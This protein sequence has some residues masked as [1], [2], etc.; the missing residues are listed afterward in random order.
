MG[1]LKEENLITLQTPLK[2]GQRVIRIGNSIIPVGVGGI[3]APGAGSDSSSVVA[4]DVTLGVVDQS[5]FFQPLRFEGTQAS[6]SG[7]AI[8]VL[9]YKSW[10]STL[11]APV[12]G[13]SMD[14]Y[15]CASVDASNSTWAGYKLEKQQNGGYAV[16]DTLTSDLEYTLAV[17]TVNFIYSKDALVTLGSFYP[18][19]AVDLLDSNT[20]FLMMGSL[21]DLSSNSVQIDNYGLTVQDGL[22]YGSTNSGYATIPAN[23]IASDAFVP[24]HDW[25]FEICFWA[26]DSSVSIPSIGT[27]IFGNG[28]VTYRFD[29][30]I[31]SSAH[32]YIGSVL[33]DAGAVNRGSYNTFIFQQS[34][35]GARRWE[36]NGNQTGENIGAVG[37]VRQYA[38]P[39]MCEKSSGGSSSNTKY[40]YPFKIKYIRISNCLRLV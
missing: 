15:K 2:Y 22:I 18:S 39:I 24:T 14:F 23:A 16:S 11:P 3:N 7:S 35:L 20:R 1:N 4:A 26:P 12:V 36:L 33:N 29:I 21:S 38:Q 30:I 37:D 31:N 8:E 32:V 19:Q 34:S 17:P 28:N 10:N 27:T 40:G 25:T 9:Q 6:N 5:G 13:G